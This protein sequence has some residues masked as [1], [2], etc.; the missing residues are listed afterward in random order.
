[1][2]NARAVMQL[3]ESILQTIGRT[4]IVRLRRVVPPNAADVLVKLEYH[5]PT[6]SYKDRMALG[7]I[8]GAERR[9]ALTSGMR[10][11]EFTGGS[12]G[13]S[14]AFVCAVKGYRFTVVTNDA[15]AIEKRLAMRAFGAE[16]IE[17]KSEGGKLTPDLVGRMRE[18]TATLAAESGTYFTDQFNNLDA[19][20][21]Y[22]QLAAELLEQA[23]GKV[24][25]Y[26]GCVGTGGMIRGVALGFAEAGCRAKVVALEPLES[27]PM[28][29]GIP[30]PH[31]VE[32]VAPGFIPP[33]MKEEPYT[34]ARAVPEKDGREMARRLAREEGIFAGTS[35]GL[36]VFA[37]IQL[38]RELGPGHTVA[39]VAVDTGNKYLAGTLY[40]PDN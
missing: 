3:P 39:T 7:M 17:I 15:V 29:G 5:N 1:M 22:K 32:G 33:H 36:N 8:E 9:G 37:A 34:E 19:L 20:E 13:N 18:L 23:G 35:S 25:A 38:A 2:N 12:T 30:G 14:L 24:D 31:T 21:G 11:L 27:S 6:G 40:S 4:P 16:V 10:V 28:S 26:C